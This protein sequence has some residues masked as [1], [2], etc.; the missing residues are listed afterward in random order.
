M[1][2]DPKDLVRM[3][4]RVEGVV[5]G[6]GFRP[7]VYGLAGKYGLAGFVGNDTRG[8]IVEAEGSA[9]ALAEFAAA[10]AHQPPPL[11][12]VE[13]I[14]SERTAP[15]GERGFRIIDSLPGPQPAVPKQQA[16]ETAGWPQALVAADTATCA[17]CLAEIADPSARRYRYPFTNCTDCGPRFT[18]VRD[19]PY[20][21]C[22][23]TMAG[24]AMCADCAREYADPADRRFHAQP[25]C[26]PACGPTL[27]LVDAAG[28]QLAGDPI[29][30]AAR[31]LH[32]GKI[33]AI[34][35]LGGY[36][37]AVRADLERAV[38]ALRARKHREDKPFAIM[39]ADLAAARTLVRLEE[40]A[41]RA[42]TGP[43]RPIVLLPRR[44]DAPVAES[45]APGA[46]ELGVMLP[47]TPL[48]HLLARRLGRPFVLTSGNL[49]DEPIAYRDED[50]L[51][52][53]APVADAFLVH[54]RPI[55]VR[56]D[57]SV[58]RLFRG[59]VLPVR[60]SRGYVPAPIP[61]K[62]PFPRPVLAC[63]AE[64]KNTFCV[65]KG[66]HAFVSHHIGDL[67]N[68]ATLR[69]FTEGIE[70][71]C[72]LLD[73]RPQVVA[74]DLHPEYLSTKY[75]LENCDAEPVAV[76]HHHAHIASCLADNG[77]TGPVIGVALD[78]L[79]YGPDGTLW[80]GELLIADLVDFERAGHLE[81]VPMPGG[82]AAIR[83][84]WRMAAAYL[85]ALYG[86]DVPDLAVVRR[87]A[88]RWAAMVSLART[89]TNAPL[90]SSAGRLFDAVAAILC[91]R[92]AISY[93]G[94][95][96]IELERR[97]DPHETGGYA[98]TVQD[99]PPLI[100][101]GGDLVR[102]T[103]GDLA[104]RVGH[105]RIAARFHNGLARALIHAV[106]LLRDRTGLRTVAL[107]G[108][109]FQNMTLLERVVTG[110]ERLEFRVLVHSRVPPNDGGISLGQAVIAAA[111]IG[112]S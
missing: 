92:D 33:L 63:G 98:V 86:D 83:E 48:H 6:V 3:R 51:Q 70:H 80:G 73:V 97:V 107:S 35:G 111:R 16:P 74:H 54:D 110:L 37:L 66:P 101:R 75:A 24:F 45:V 93:E 52:R 87:N 7:F 11:A 69:S 59:R 88:E 105:G 13:R 19:V 10:L 28:R 18:I 2:T 5:Q 49:S 65:G 12:V 32:D 50:A 20:D 96:A 39:A 1:L 78:G 38:A 99:G 95:A 4:I 21:R 27:R 14:T 67:E 90:T 25:V 85:D 53:L 61:V 84:P 64:L 103:V 36:H 30:A 26:C 23:T 77:A 72:R 55:Q 42:L 100:I 31:R 43:A 9:P 44:V 106:Q 62:R 82:T 104:N 108:G 76:Q 46:R 91:G 15:T 71:F 102:A 56:T 89:G 41:E 58:V 40:G 57:D 29:V 109:V 60:R 17:A 79:G 81:T 47:Y 112:S 22:R 68:Y 34:K 8:V 94:Q